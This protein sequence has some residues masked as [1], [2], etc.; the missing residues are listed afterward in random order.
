[1][2]GLHCIYFSYTN[3]KLSN[4]KKKIKY[5]NAEHFLIIKIW[6]TENLISENASQGIHLSGS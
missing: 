1:M 2:E 6:K 4:S 3:T 5:K